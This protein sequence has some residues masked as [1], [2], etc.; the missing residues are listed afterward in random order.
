MIN[1]FLNEKSLLIK[2]KNTKSV[3][4]TPNHIRESFQ[5]NPLSPVLLIIY[6]SDISREHTNNNSVVVCRALRA[7]GRNYI[8]SYIV[9]YKNI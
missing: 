8:I 4:L 9:K 7:Y 6:L 5:E 3:G 2:I 1:G